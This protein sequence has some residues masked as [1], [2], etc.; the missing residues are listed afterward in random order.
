V[1]SIVAAKCDGVKVNVQAFKLKDIWALRVRPQMEDRVR[2]LASSTSGSILSYATAIW[3]ASR[4][5]IS[6]TAIK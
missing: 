5:G 6:A 3:S 2:E 1:S 4:S